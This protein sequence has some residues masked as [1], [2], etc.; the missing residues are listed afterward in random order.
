[1][2]MNTGVGVPGVKCE[3]RAAAER[4]KSAF[5]A[6]TPRALDGPLNS[7]QKSIDLTPRAPNAG[8]IGGAGPAF[9]A[10]TTSL[11]AER[12]AREHRTRESV[13]AVTYERPRAHLTVCAAAA[14]VLDMSSETAN[15]DGGQGIARLAPALSHFGLSSIM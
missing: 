11:R 5:Q 7:L 14:A 13:A 3:V 8:P 6:Q 10:P 2:V 15:E 1:M 9:P 12:S 4:P